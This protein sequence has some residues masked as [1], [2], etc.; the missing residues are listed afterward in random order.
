[1]SKEIKDRP[2]IK[3]II[4]PELKLNFRAQGKI[5][6]L[7]LRSWSVGEEGSGPGFVSYQAE[8]A[9]P[10]GSVGPRWKV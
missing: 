3:G 9:F 4:H 7:G 8:N 2:L 6:V 10:K 1:M 5:F